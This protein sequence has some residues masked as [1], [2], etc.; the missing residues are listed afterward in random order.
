MWRVRIEI[1]KADH[2]DGVQTRTHCRKTIAAKHWPQTMARKTANTMDSQKAT[3]NTKV[4]RQVHR[5]VEEGQGEM[6]HRMEGT[7]KKLRANHL[8][9]TTVPKMAN[10]MGT[11]VTDNLKVKAQV[12]RQSRVKGNQDPAAEADETL[13]PP[14]STTTRLTHV[15]MLLLRLERYPKLIARQ[16]PGD[17]GTRSYINFHLWSL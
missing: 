1:R 8:G 15:S 2:A 12:R 10:M 17:T 13:V 11:Q 3:R 5:A 14:T 9:R 4:K 16:S 7:A 6:I